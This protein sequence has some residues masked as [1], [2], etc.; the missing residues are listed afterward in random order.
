MVVLVKDT[1]THQRAFK[2]AEDSAKRLEKNTNGRYKILNTKVDPVQKKTVVEDVAEVKENPIKPFVSIMPS[3]GR[4]E[5]ETTK[6]AEKLMK[7]NNIDIFH[8]LGFK[9]VYKKDVENYLKKQ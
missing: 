3:I 8:F 9:K 2:M 1:K 5:I 7:E 6:A 4:G